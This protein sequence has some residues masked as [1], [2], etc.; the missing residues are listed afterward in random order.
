MTTF[1]NEFDPFAA[2]WLRNLSQAGEITKGVVDERD[3]RELKPED[4][5]GYE[6]CHFF[7]GIGGWSEAL[8]RARFP[9][10]VR[11]WTASLPCT[12][13][14][15]AGNRLGVQDERHL[16]PSF[17]KLVDQCK[18]TVV[19]GEQ[20]SSPLGRSWLD[21]VRS[22]MEAMGYEVGAADLC[23]GS[24]NSPHR[25]SRLFWVAYS[26]SAWRCEREQ[27]EEGQP[28]EF[29]GPGKIF[30]DWDVF[31]RF[32]DKRIGTGVRAMAHGLQ[33]SLGPV[34]PELQG[35]VSDARS[36]L[37]GR[38]KGYGNAIVPQVAAEF[39]MAF[40]EAVA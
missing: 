9:V 3:F 37:K 21:G 25:R 8:R 6:Q 26:K 1:Y 33:R 31:S 24:L 17:A 36:N 30:G 18:P 23:A 22:E 15:L 16:W 32:G 5:E 12:P 38:L 11:L 20:T 35:M 7:A 19:F 40:K 28:E 10:G 29:R 13:F 14:S 2:R 4:V 27:M 39:I 34:K